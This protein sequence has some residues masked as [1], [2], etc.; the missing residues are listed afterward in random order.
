MIKT[1][2]HSVEELW[3]IFEVDE[4]DVVFG[5]R[6]FDGERQNHGDIGFGDDR[7]R[8][9][10]ELAIVIVRASE[11]VGGTYFFDRT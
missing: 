11:D 4:F 7:H 3:A 8:V 9:D 10:N 2:S 5:G 6:K 1:G